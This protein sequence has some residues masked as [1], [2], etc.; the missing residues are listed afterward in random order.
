MEVILSSLSVV[1]VNYNAGSVL[2]KCVQSLYQYHG[3]SADIIVIDNNSSDGSIQSLLLVY[4]QIKCVIN[5]KNRGFSKACNQGAALSNSQYIAFVNPDCFFNQPVLAYLVNQLFEKPD[6]AIASCCIRNPDGTEQLGSRRYLPTFF[7][8]IG[9]YTRLDKIPLLKKIFTGVNAI[10]QPLPR[11]WCCVE[12]VSGAFFVINRAVFDSID[13]FDE[14]YPL[15]FEDLDLFERVKLAGYSIGFEPSLSVCHHK[16]W[17]SSD[18]Q[19]IAKW[20]KKGLVRF[21]QKNRFAL[22]AKVISIMVRILP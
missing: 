8:V 1:I 18:Y 15:H 17:S 9:T 20:K 11:L 12:A 6:F 14:G 10:D 5:K 13:G 3:V 4:P 21:F 19:N 7:K 16:G 2:K 22:S